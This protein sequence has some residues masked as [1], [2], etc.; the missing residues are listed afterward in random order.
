MCD[1]AEKYNALT[2]L[3]QVHVVGRYGVRGGGIAEHDCVMHRVD[4]VT[5]TLAKGYGVMGGYIA[6][7][8][9][10]CDAARSFAPGFIF[11]TSLAPTIAAGALASIRH[12]RPGPLQAGDGHATRPLWDLR[13]AH[14][15]RILP[16][17]VSRPP[18]I[19]LIHECRNDP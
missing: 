18:S 19:V 11:T 8:R 10:L 12:R 2:Y 9:D 16:R 13:A 17:G 5:G 14:Q 1:L 6:G 3:D 15:L 7:A 4:I